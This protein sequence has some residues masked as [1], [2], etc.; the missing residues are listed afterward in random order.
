MTLSARTLHLVVF[1]SGVALLPAVVALGDVPPV[2]GVDESL[3]VALRPAVVGLHQRAT[4]IVTGGG[5]SALE[6]RL[7]GATD[8]SGKLLPWQRLRL[9]E[10]AWRAALPSPALHG[11]YPVLLRDRVQAR[12]LGSHGLRLR[13]FRR[14]TAARPAFEHPIDVAYWWVRAVEHARLVAVKAWSRPAFDRRDGRFHRLFVVAY[15]PAGHP[16]T[17]DRLGM[18]ITSFRDAVDSRWRLLEATVFP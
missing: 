8:A 9:V 1:L 6:A 12:A 4:I 7:A 5:V 14:G 16:A 3:H 18:F 15:S 10:G 17:R 11:V 13:V 2:T